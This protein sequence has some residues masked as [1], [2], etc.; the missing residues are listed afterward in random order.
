MGPERCNGPADCG[1]AFGSIRINIASI[2]NLAFC[3]GVDAVNC[4]ICQRPSRKNIVI[5][6][7]LLFESESAF[8]AS[9]PNLS[10]RV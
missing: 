3:V 4:V 6:G 9:T 7:N 10:A 8:S 2:L 1:I 5:R